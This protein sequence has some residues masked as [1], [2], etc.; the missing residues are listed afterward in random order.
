MQ[1]K[2]DLNVNFVNCFGIVLRKN[3]KT[4]QDLLKHNI[5]ESQTKIELPESML[6]YSVH[7][8]SQ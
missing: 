6:V 8:T 2:D 3:F 4:N 7:K 1:Q 5:T